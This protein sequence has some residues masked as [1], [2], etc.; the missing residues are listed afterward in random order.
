MTHTCFAG[1]L[2]TELSRDKIALGE[3][4]V[5]TYTLNN[6]TSRVAPNFSALLKDFRLINTNYGNAINMING[7]TTTQTFWRLWLEPK[8]VGELIIPALNFGDENSVPRKLTVT[9]AQMNGI[10]KQNTSVFVRGEISSTSP[11]VQSQV[12]YTFKL[13]YSS[14]IRESRLELPQ[15]KDA[16]F[17]QLSDDQNY[18]TT[19]NGKVYNVLEKNF[20]LFPKKAG[21]ITIAPIQLHTQTIDETPGNTDDWFTFNQARNITAATKTFNISVRD[22]PPHF[23][24]TTW[25]P[26]KDLSLTE[27][28]SNHSGHWESGTPVTRT[29]TMTAQGLRADQLPDIAIDKIEGVNT[30]VDRP[31]RNNIIQHNMVI[32]VLE[33]KVTY[34]PNSSS[35][36]TIPPLK[37][38]W[39]NTRTNT[40]AVAELNSMSIQVKNI[41]NNVNPVANLPSSQPLPVTNSISSNTQT[42]YQSVWFWIACALLAV[43][44]ITLLFMLRRKSHTTI[45]KPVLDKQTL[46][47]SDK[48]F[49][50]ACQSGHAV[51]AQQYLLTWA[52][53]RW[54]NMPMNLTILRELIS[55]APFNEAL[56]ELEQALYSKKTVTWHGE[57]LLS[58]FLRIKKSGNH[59]S[60]IKSKGKIIDPL[61]PLN[62]CELR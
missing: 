54:P 47:L 5:V 2:N 14:Q 4:V 1:N 11:Y 12:L 50:H 57:K 44:I 9:A 61:P 34:I 41:A 20:A 38:N 53:E 7:V 56:Q 40:N 28:W 59:Y 19:I 26:A 45:P 21:T 15:I 25:L 58:A 13:Y 6:N 39:W 23:Q 42:F 51:Q 33:Q 35:S 3:Y 27:Q 60:D 16:T 62:P 8:N 48:D 32:G 22:V 24:G 37:M 55:D 49:T 43:W 46:E 18:Q 36:L 10:D 17:F 31:K 29:I 30:Y 52:K